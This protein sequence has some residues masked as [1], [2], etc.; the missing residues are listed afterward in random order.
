VDS[1]LERLV[2]FVDERAKANQP[3][4][5]NKA[6]NKL[7]PFTQ[8]MILFASE[9]ME[10]EDALGAL[11]TE[12]RTQP[13]ESYAQLLRLGNVAQAKLHLDHVLQVVHKCPVS[14]PMATVN[15][16]LNGRLTWSDHT[17]PEAFSVF[18]CFK[19]GPS[20][21]GTA[22]DDFLALQ[23][24]SSEGQGLSEADVIRSTKV[25]FR[26]PQDEHQLES[27]SVRSASFC[28]SFLDPMPPS[29]TPSGAG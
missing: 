4:K 23:L 12:P 22:H 7:E 19:P 14:L 29:A 6:F 8:D 9:P 21:V 1:G 15:A 2:Q 5:D 20:A 10:V 16:I 11:S 25:T 27:S 24:K 18:A 13:V 26:A 3:T 17:N 28:P